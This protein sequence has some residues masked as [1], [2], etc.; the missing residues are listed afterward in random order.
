M[1][2]PPLYRR[3]AW[4]RFFAGAVIGGVTSWLIFLY[5][6]GVQQEKQITTLKAQQK[7]IHELKIKNAVWEHDLN[8]LNDE[9]EQG[10]SIQ[11]VKVTITNGETYGLDK[12]SVA[13]AEDALIEDLKSLIAKNVD[14]VFKG[15]MLLKKS[16]ENKI[17]EINK[18]RYALEVSEILF[19]SNMYIEI[20]L[21]RL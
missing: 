1:R 15:K 9:T 5:M 4:Q 20:K 10:L 18:K 6:F 14:T 2:I 3:P 21:K 8:K 11:D 12:L 16:I 19:Y 13:E 7:T 17:L